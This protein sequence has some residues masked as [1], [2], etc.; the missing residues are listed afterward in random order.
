MYDNYLIFPIIP[1]CAFG[2]QMVENLDLWYNGG[3]LWFVIY[4]N[5]D[6]RV[7]IQVLRPSYLHGSKDAV[8]HPFLAY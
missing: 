3:L 6:C 7:K 1:S 4:H 5:R 2:V 8:F